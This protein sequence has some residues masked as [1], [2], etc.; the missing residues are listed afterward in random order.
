MDLTDLRKFWWVWIILCI[1]VFLLLGYAL[2][3]ENQNENQ[4]LKEYN[5]Q[6]KNQ[7]SDNL[8][9]NMKY[10]I[11]PQSQIGTDC[12]ENLSGILTSPI[13]DP[14]DLLAL[15]PLGNLN[16]PGHT[17]PVD[18]I[19]FVFNL[20]A[21]HIPVYNPASGTITDI[22]A[23]TRY[24]ANS[25]NFIES[26]YAITYTLCNGLIIVPA[27]YRELSDE[28]KRTI[29]NSTGDCKNSTKFKG[30]P[31]KPI[32]AVGCDYQLDYPVKAGDIAGYADNLE[33]WAIDYNSIP[34]QDVNWKLYNYNNYGYA[35]CFFDLY[36]GNL[37]NEYYQKFG[38]SDPKYPERFEQRT[39]EPV[40]GSI[41]QD[42][43]GT[44]QGG[45][46]GD[47]NGDVSTGYDNKDLA[48]VYDNL[49]PTKAAISI[50]GQISNPGLM[51]FHPKDSGKNNRIFSDV[52][53]DGYIYCY[54]R[55]ENSQMYIDGKILVQLLD[56]H[57]LKIEHQ[58]GN[59][60]SSESFVNPFT[61][62]R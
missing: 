2:H 39:I 55:D 48:L 28:L 40:C 6:T 15:I 4:P 13:V 58:D 8:K 24:D 60:T 43:P 26:S 7:S 54:Q 52:K 17:F 59:C 47:K 19:Y 9:T 1:G 56:D 49:D 25:G 18:H 45:W 61:Y 21:T 62:Q 36:S 3:I 20:N 10:Y 31:N 41:V 53:A 42:I 22:G 50:G 16:P 35:F 5:T 32:I 44:I 37:K 11:P 46:F 12:P 33:I 51:F 14:K 57:N 29:D 34:R 30:D 27:G 38:F 23:E